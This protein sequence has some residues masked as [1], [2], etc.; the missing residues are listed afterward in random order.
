MSRHT[1]TMLLSCPRAT[2]APMTDPHGHHTVAREDLL[3]IEMTL[4]KAEHLWPKRGR[5]GDHDRLK[6]MAQRIVDRLELC[7]M[8]C[9]AKG[10]APLHGTLAPRS[11]PRQD[12]AAD[13]GNA[14]NA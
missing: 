13:E 1:P 7:G 10:P 6:P 12:G 14:G 5:R 3:A 11:A 4:R 2:L 8:R 9:V